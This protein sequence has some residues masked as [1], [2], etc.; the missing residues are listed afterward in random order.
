[1]KFLEKGIFIII[2][3]VLIEFFRKQA[4]FHISSRR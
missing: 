2:A 3:I 4:V 1:M